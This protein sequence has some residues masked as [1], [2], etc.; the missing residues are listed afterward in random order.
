MSLTTTL[1]QQIRSS[2]QLSVCHI[3]EKEVSPSI[4]SVLELSLRCLEIR[5]NKKL[6]LEYLLVDSK[7]SSCEVIK[8]M[9]LRSPLH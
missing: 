7:A 4:D 9:T 8:L 5:E 3:S 6:G 1:I 2:N